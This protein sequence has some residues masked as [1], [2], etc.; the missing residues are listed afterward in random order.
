MNKAMANPIEDPFLDIQRWVE[1]DPLGED[2]PATSNTSNIT[3]ESASVHRSMIKRFNQHSIMVLKAGEN[4]TDKNSNDIVT[5]PK[6]EINGIHSDK[7]NNESEPET[8]RRK[9]LEKI[10]YD[11]LQ[12]N[13]DSNKIIQLE[14]SKVTFCSPILTIITLFY[15]F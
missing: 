7:A 2:L 4:T 14:L 8:K 3:S 12:G 15:C 13:D 11:D 9:I 5:D 10:S 6:P 1:P